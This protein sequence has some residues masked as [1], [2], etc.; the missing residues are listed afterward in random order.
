MA[1]SPFGMPGGFLFSIVPVLV[2]VGFVIVLTV[3]VVNLIRGAQQY[4][5]NN[6]SPVLTV[7]AIVVTKREDVYHHHHNTGANNMNTMHTSSTTY[8][9]TFEVQSGDR[10]EFEVRDTEYG[11]LADR[12][13]GK[14][15][16]QGTRYLGFER[17]SSF[18]E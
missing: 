7:D 18:V 3:I 9:V 8:F 15:T 13:T 17:N 10:M 4:K 14:L 6:E 16:F 1:S 5:R 2:A 11:M 12:D